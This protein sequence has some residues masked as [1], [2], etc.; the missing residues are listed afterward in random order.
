MSQVGLCSSFP[1]LSQTFPLEFLVPYPGKWYIEAKQ[2]GF[3]TNRMLL[4]LVILVKAFNFF[5]CNYFKH[6][7]GSPF[8]LTISPLLCTT[9]C[10]LPPCFLFVLPYMASG[11]YLQEE[12][13]HVTVTL[14]LKMK[15]AAW[16]LVLP[17][18]KLLHRSLCK[19][20]TCHSPPSLRLFIYLSFAYPSSFI[21]LFM[22]HHLSS[23]DID[24]SSALL[25]TFSIF[26]SFY[27]SLTCDEQK[28]SF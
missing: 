17:L 19:W 28:Y 16:P 24:I 13:I 4:L 26:F 20:I 9:V 23:L 2:I 5:L 22:C 10:Q 25:Q 7:T 15:M 12:N 18:S 11:L 3:I 14:R 1:Q 27:L 6:A 21:Y 8:S